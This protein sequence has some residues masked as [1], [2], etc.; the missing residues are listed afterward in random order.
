MAGPLRVGVIGCGE[1]TQ[2]IHLPALHEL[3]ELFTV[4]ALCDVSPSVLAALGAMHPGSRRYTDYRKLLADPAV[5]VVLVANP[6]AYHA[7]AVTTAIAAG[8]HVLLEKPIAVTIADA[9]AMIAAESKAKVTVQV[10]YMRRYAPAYVEAVAAVARL[11]SDIVLARVH[12]VI[13]PNAAII[14]NTSN[15]F[16]PNDLPASLVAEGKARLAAGI[17]AIDR[18]RRR[19][20]RGRLLPSP[21]PEQ[22]R[23]VGDARADRDAHGG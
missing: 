1:V 6:D 3:R 19:A 22:P 18:H 7:E 21:Q 12:D 23:T 8:K 2:I 9:D 4:T 20:A 5:D 16:R 11:R 15:I 13:G 17:A 10:G 14:D